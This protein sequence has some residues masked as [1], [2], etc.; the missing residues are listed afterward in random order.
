MK[1]LVEFPLEG[2][3]SAIVE[4]DEPAPPGTR[5]ASRAGKVDEEASQTFEASLDRVKPLSAALIGRMRDLAEPPDEIA[6]Q[7]GVK[8]SGSLGAIIA[9]A[10][11]E[12]NYSVTLKWQRPKA[13]VGA[14]A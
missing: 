4:V 14:S 10:S 1:R 9:S 11:G 5:P 3:G 8:L 13:D 12:A 6:I 7:F 2:G